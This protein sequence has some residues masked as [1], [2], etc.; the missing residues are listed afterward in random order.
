MH[1]YAYQ[2]TKQLK[3]KLFGGNRCIEYGNAFFIDKTKTSPGTNKGTAKSSITNEIT[4]K[5][6]CKQK[7]T[8]LNSNDSFSGDRVC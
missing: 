7:Q 4:Q 8:N 2:L 1:T 6:N 5:K 3:Q